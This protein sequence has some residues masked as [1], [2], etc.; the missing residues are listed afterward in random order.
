M[1]AHLQDEFIH[2]AAFEGGFPFRFVGAQ[3]S[4]FG[5]QFAPVQND[6]NVCVR[7][8]AADVTGVRG[9]LVRDT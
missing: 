1:T 6:K 4:L 2:G 5:A 9:D 8:G 7:T 3:T